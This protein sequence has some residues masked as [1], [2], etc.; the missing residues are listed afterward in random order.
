MTR[1]KLLVFGRF[2]KVAAMIRFSFVLLALALPLF[3]QEK[4]GPLISITSPDTGTTFA[5]ATMKT[6]ALVWNKKDKVLSAQLTFT[7]APQNNGQPNE[8]THSFRLP[9][10]TLD[11]ARGVFFATSPKGEAVPVARLKKELFFSTIQVLPNATVRVLRNHGDITVI[12][13]AIRPDDPALHPSD[14]TNSDETHAV[15]IR[16]IVQ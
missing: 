14:S 8:D 13:E 2:V 10:V 1:L 9:G 4:G 11:P 5:Y 6:R 7:D 15:D 16:Q 3:A 12:L